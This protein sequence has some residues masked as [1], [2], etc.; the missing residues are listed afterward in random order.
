MD[1]LTDLLIEAHLSELKNISA[2]CPKRGKPMIFQYRY[3]IDFI[4]ELIMIMGIKVVR[5][6]KM[7]FL[8]PM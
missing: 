7:A 5:I 3:G 6:D 4:Q 1:G 8:G 2:S